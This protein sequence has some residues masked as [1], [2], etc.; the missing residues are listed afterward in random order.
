MSAC[1]ISFSKCE[2]ANAARKSCRYIYTVLLSSQNVQTGGNNY[3]PKQWVCTAKA[4]S[5]P[6]FALYRRYQGHNMEELDRVFE[7]VF[8][9][10]L[11]YDDGM[12]DPCSPNPCLNQGTCVATE[13][14]FLCRCTNFFTGMN[15]ERALRPCK[16][17][18]CAHGECVLKKYSPYYECRCHYPYRGVTCSSVE[19]LCKRNPCKNGGTCLVNNNKFACACTNNYY[20]KFCEIESKDYCYRNDGFR[21]RGHISHTAGGYSCLPWDSYHLT[22]E[23]INAFMPYNLYYG[24]GEHNF[25]RNPDGAEKPWCYY[26]DESRRLRWDACALYT[27][28]TVLRPSVVATTLRPKSTLPPRTTAMVNTSFPACGIRELPINTRGRIIGGKRTQPGR[29]P[30]LA[31]LQLK[32]RVGHY[33]PGHMCGG[34]LIGECWILTAAHCVEALPSPSMWKVLLGRVDMQQ[35]ETSEQVFEVEKILTHENYMHRESSLHYD[36]ALMKLK[37]VMGKCAQESRFVKTACLPDREFLPGKVC[38]IAGWG[39][40]ETGFSAQLLE[41]TVQVISESNCSDP[42]SYGKSIDSSM[43]CAGVP[44]GGVDSCQGDSGGPLTCEGNGV[45]RVAGVVSWG[46][47]CGLKDKPGVYAHVYRFVPWIKKMIK[48]NP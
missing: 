19:E 12:E 1:V 15:C 9:H 5:S 43:L 30:W 47:Q 44:E 37:K 41:A 29:H 3:N 35:N 14:G 6:D 23:V 2:D 16:K 31:S 33:P 40:T 36:I 11:Y 38:E 39:M 45:A 24:I 27:C 46:E 13:E 10:S 18:T 4:S 26:L 28:P 21:Y 25:C 32:Q 42:K 17:D 22:R 7:E 8:S 48:A 20:G 34:T